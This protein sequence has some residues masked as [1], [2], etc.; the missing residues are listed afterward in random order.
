MKMNER[1]YDIDW[2]RIIAMLAIFIYHCTRF[3]DTEGW[4]IKS[5]EQSL[6]MEITMDGLIWPWVME[7]FFLVSGIGTWYVL[8]SRS[9][10][11]YLWNRVK[12]LIIPLYTVGL[13]VLVPPQFYFEIFTNEGYRDTFWNSIPLY[14]ADFGLPSLSVDPGSLIPY[15]F[16]GHLWFLRY[17][18][19]IS[20]VTLPLLFHLKSEKGQLR[21][22]NLADWCDRRGGIF[23]FIL[24]LTFILISLRWI[25]G[26]QRSW[27]DFLWYAA[28]FVI[29]YVFAADIRFTDIIKRYWRICLAAWIVSFLSLGLIVFV[30]GYEP[31]PDRQTFSF[32]YVLFQITYSVFSWSSVVFMLSIGAKYLNFN[33]KI[34]AYG[35]E[36][37]LPFYLLHQTILLVVGYFVIPWNVNAL[38]KFF[39]IT[40]VSFSLILTLYEVLIRRLNVA[41]FLFGMKPKKKS[42]AAE[43]RTLQPVS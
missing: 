17:L 28:Y 7:L 36:A 16:T 25:F 38:F 23:I 21:I 32:V 34:L 33:H 15:P 8:K 6:F 20:L 41:R 35:N 43:P 31:L 13:F 39:V 11:E 3:F 14:F 19:L 18:F 22:A 24:P 2:L 1:R 42:N 27:A 26:T 12:R 40:A 9:A 10:G 4:H 37:V 29:G 5:Q 30:L